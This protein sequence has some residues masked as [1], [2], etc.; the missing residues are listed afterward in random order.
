METFETSWA[1]L[2]ILLG[3]NHGP[4][5]FKIK[6]IKVCVYTCVCTCASS[7]GGQKGAANVLKLELQW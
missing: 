1:L 6:K 2:R 5:I 7:C 3:E 4:F